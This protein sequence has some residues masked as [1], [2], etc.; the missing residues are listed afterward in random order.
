M[1]DYVLMV[2]RL[3]VA[4]VTRRCCRGSCAHCGG[5]AGPPAT[6]PADDPVPAGVPDEVPVLGA[7]SAGGVEPVELGGVDVEPVAG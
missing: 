7:G 2:E 3:Q 4:V 6:V 5:V 1:D